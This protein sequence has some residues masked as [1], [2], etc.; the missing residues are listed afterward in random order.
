MCSV[1]VTGSRV[2][3]DHNSWHFQYLKSQSTLENLML[4]KGSDDENRYMNRYWNQSFGGSTYT[5]YVLKYQLVVYN[6]NTAENGLNYKFDGLSL[7]DP[8]TDN[9]TDLELA[10]YKVIQKYCHLKCVF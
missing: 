5:Y 3:D 4:N 1:Q 7:L 10:L 2:Y 6:K 9:K 8:Y